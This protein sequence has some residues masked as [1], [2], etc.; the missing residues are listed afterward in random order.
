MA[1]III[2]ISMLAKLVFL[3]YSEVDID[4]CEIFFKY[5]FCP[6]LTFLTVKMTFKVENEM[7]H[8]STFLSSSDV[9]LIS[10]VCLL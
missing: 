7:T 2:Y 1:N 9:K 3:R 10:H 8:T 4:V 5:L 6:H